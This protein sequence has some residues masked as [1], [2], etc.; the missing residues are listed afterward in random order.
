[1]EHEPWYCEYS[2]EVDVRPAFAWSYWTDIGNWV[3]PPAQ[4]SLDGAFAAG[5]QGMTQMPG[6]EPIGWRIA[7]VGGSRQWRRVSPPRFRSR[8]TGQ[9]CRFTGDL[10]RFPIAGPESRNASS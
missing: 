3:D 10:R 1:M 5:S 6:H 2:V 7:A 9:S 4:F 8:W